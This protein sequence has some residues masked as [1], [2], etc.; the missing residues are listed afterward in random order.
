[1]NITGP[2][3]PKINRALKISSTKD[4]SNGPT[5]VCVIQ[6]TMV[7]ALAHSLHANLVQLNLNTVDKV[8]NAAIMNQATCSRA[9]T[10]NADDVS[11][12][13]IHSYSTSS[14]LAALIEAAYDCEQP[15]VVLM[16]DDL[17]W[18]THDDEASGVMLSAIDSKMIT[19][20]KLLF[21]AIEPD[22][23]LKV[24]QPTPSCKPTVPASSTSASTIDESPSTGSSSP[25]S[26]SFSLPFSISN[27][28]FFF[29]S[30]LSLSRFARRLSADVLFS[31]A[32]LSSFSV[33]PS[34][35]D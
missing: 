8:R 2:L 24:G 32:L 27:S 20:T 16:N 14:I 23:A 15:T 31:F 12:G 21:I 7:K 18:L 19:S 26:F 33:T 30:S 1:V 9:T 17:E 28:A 13:S 25:F 34:D 10:S 22:E 4:E 29:R 3:V 35:S 11:M 6:E 5:G